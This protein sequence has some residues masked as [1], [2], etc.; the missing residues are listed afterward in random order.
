MLKAHFNMV[1]YLQFLTMITFEAEIEKISLTICANAPL[2]H[3][4]SK[5]AIIAAL[6]N[7]AIDIAK[8]V[9]LGQSTF[10][11]ADYAEGRVAF[12]QKRKPA[13]KGN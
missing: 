9:A 2:S 8:A 13:F 10:E 3:I 4:A 7:D 1:F 12:K 6:S 11:S 5:Q